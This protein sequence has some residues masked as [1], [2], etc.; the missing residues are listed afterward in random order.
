MEDRFSQT[1]LEKLNQRLQLRLAA[2]HTQSHSLSLF[3]G[4]SDLTLNNDLEKIILDPCN[5]ATALEVVLEA[6]EGRKPYFWLNKVLEATNPDYQKSPTA[7]V[8]HL[9]FTVQ[10]AAQ[11]DAFKAIRFDR[12]SF[13]EP[14]RVQINLGTYGLFNSC[15]ISLPANDVLSVRAVAAQDADYSPVVVQEGQSLRLE[16]APGFVDHLLK[17]RKFYPAIL[18]SMVRVR[19]SDPNCSFYPLARSMLVRFAASRKAEKSKNAARAAD[20]TA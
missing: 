13:D 2:D 17:A 16:S 7:L 15:N 19:E 1:A 10:V 8:V 3:Q 5:P 9:P 6:R 14:P 12:G 20:P 11:N 4:L 18:E